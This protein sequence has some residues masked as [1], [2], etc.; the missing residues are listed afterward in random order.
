[1]KRHA[2]KTQGQ[3]LNMST[4]SAA[5]APARPHAR[6]VQHPKSP[7]ADDNRRIVV[8]DTETTGLEVNQGHRVIE[9]GCIEMVRGLRTGR[10]F[11]EYLN[12]DRSVPPE[13]TAIHGLRDADLASA[14]RFA[15]IGRP[16]LEF[17]HGAVLVVHHA[18][19]DIDFL[20]AELRRAGSKRSLANFVAEIVDTLPIA[21][22]L[23]PGQR[24]DLRSLCRHYRIDTSGDDRHEALA[25]ADLLASLYCAMHLSQFSLALSPDTE[26]F[27]AQPAP[28]HVRTPLL[29]QQPS[30]AELAAHEQF[31]D[32][33]DRQCPTGSLWRR[34]R[35]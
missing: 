2:G 21:Q 16:F 23:H 6:L 30:A 9:I 28:G 10:T 13:A 14:P 26:N 3:P 19:F 5:Y 29:V 8:L 27:A 33:I 22:G 11:H 34:L 12:P 25:D 18:P 7:P 31:L 32:H 20:D 1:M 17:V 15:E 35:P 24:H 4:V